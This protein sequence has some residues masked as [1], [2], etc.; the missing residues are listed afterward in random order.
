MYGLLTQFLHQRQKVLERGIWEGMERPVRICPPNDY[1]I[2][3]FFQLLHAYSAMIWFL[4]KHE[5]RVRKQNDVYARAGGCVAQVSC[6]PPQPL[7][8]FELDPIAASFS[9]TLHS[10][11]LQHASQYN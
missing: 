11:I 9:A 8:A 3:Y 5:E 1:T 4:R 7:S 2:I 6:F 10:L